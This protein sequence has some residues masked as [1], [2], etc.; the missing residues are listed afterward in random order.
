MVGSGGLCVLK[1]GRACGWRGEGEGLAGGNDIQPSGPEGSVGAV[2][3]GRRGGGGGQGMMWG[4][5]G[6]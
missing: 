3:W 2:G 4:G 1:N 5:L 6:A